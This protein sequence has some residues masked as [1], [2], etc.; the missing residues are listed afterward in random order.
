VDLSGEKPRLLRRG[1]LDVDA[2]LGE[3]VDATAGGAG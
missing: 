1:D 3:F 2:D